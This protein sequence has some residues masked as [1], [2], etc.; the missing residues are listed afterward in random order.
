LEYSDDMKKSIMQIS[1]N[2]AAVTRQFV[3]IAQSIT[4]SMVPVINV[5]QLIGSQIASIVNMMNT[6]AVEMNKHIQEQL[7]T[8]IQA[9]SQFHNL[10]LK[11]VVPNELAKTWSVLPQKVEEILPA[12]V[13][14]ADTTPIVSTE[15]IEADSSE[16]EVKFTWRD[17]LSILGVL[18]ALLSYLNDLSSKDDRPEIIEIHQDV[19]NGVEQTITYVIN[20]YNIIIED[21]RPNSLDDQ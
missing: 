5:S 1:E 4:Q 18:L 6:Y 11:V 10:E 20:N 8:V 12:Q 17:I 9:I 19:K 15:C 14:H 2:M 3:Q 7:R 13:E 16:S 21:D